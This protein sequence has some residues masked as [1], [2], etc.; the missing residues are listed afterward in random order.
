MGQCQANTYI[1]YTCPLCSN[2][3]IY[4]DA[5]DWMTLLDY[6]DENDSP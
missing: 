4:F 2:H 1:S 3:N 5:C 6:I